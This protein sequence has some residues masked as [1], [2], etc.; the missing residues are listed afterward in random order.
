[1][2]RKRPCRK[3]EKAQCLDKGKEETEEVSFWSVVLSEDVDCDSTSIGADD[4]LLVGVVV[5][6][7]AVVLVESFFCCWEVVG[8]DRVAINLCCAES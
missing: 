4:L 8:T 2:E 5:V 3:K 1:M 6:V 7:V